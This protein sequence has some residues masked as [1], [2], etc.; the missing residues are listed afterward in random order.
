M[1]KA[2]TTTKEKTQTSAPAKQTKAERL[3][4][5]AEQKKALLEEQRALRA[6]QEETKEERKAARKVQSQARKDIIPQK[7]AIRDLCASVY[8]TFSKGGSEPV[9]KLADDLMEAATTLA[10]TIRS[11][12]EAEKT[13][14]GVTPEVEDEEEEL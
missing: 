9:G 1:T 5:I 12:A 3:K 11:F 14:E 2:K 10:G 7:A 4:Q 13:M 6:E 8:S